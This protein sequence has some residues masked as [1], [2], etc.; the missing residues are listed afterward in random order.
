MN[1]NKLYLNTKNILT[2][3]KN[4]ATLES[5]KSFLITND[6]QVHS[7]DSVPKDEEI[8]LENWDIAILDESILSEKKDFISLLKS[9]FP[10]IKLLLLRRKT[11]K[12]TA[13]IDL[14]Y[15]DYVIEQPIQWA[16]LEKIFQEIIYFPLRNKDILIIEDARISL[17]KMIHIVQSL[18]GNAFG[19]SD[20]NH[21][22]QILSQSYDIA[23]IDLIMKN[24]TTIDFIQVIKEKY[25]NIHIIVVSAMPHALENNMDSFSMVDFIYPKP[26]DEKKLQETLIDITEQPFSERRRSI[27]KEGIP[28]CWISK[29]NREMDLNEPFE[30][31]FIVDLSVDGLSFHSHL[32]Y[33]TGDNV[34]IWL[35][36]KS[37]SNAHNLFE[38]RG[39]IKWCKKIE[40]EKVSKDLTAYGL[41]LEPGLS[42]DYKE[43]QKFIAHYSKVA[44]SF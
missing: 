6:A 29:Y 16:E 27:R 3:I 30:S 44:R 34:T 12:N 25:P 10:T 42:R 35:L 40:D 18:G 15:I 26:W 20:I 4:P 5:L 41:E 23:I 19:Y 21:E 2:I 17:K 43:F 7:Y 13:E 37:S 11:A 1:S 28:Y 38:L 32:E 39:I 9:S 22:S 31:P 33:E 36:N 8:L 24:G 14:N